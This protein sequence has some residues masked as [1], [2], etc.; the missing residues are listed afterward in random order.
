VPGAMAEP[1]TPVPIAPADVAAGE[2]PVPVAPRA[3]PTTGMPVVRAPV[4]VALG[5]AEPPTAAPV[6]ALAATPVPKAPA[7]AAAGGL[8]ARP[9]EAVAGGETAAVW[10]TGAPITGPP[11][12]GGTTVAPP[13]AVV[14]APPMAVDGW[15]GAASE[16]WV[17]DELTSSLR[18]Q[19]AAARPHAISA[20]AWI[21]PSMVSSFSPS[22]AAASA[23]A[24]P[25]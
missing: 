2:P 23:A 25:L 18:L 24:R 16:V 5:T 21:L 10:P 1:A 17:A 15:V 20:R 13:G 3:P 22:A 12:D 7:E 6:V 19:P 9:P 4:A 8:T 11:S 14:I